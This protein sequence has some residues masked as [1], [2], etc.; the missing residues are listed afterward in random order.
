M[1]YTRLNEEEREIIS[2]GLAQNKSIRSI[3]KELGR[4]TSTI[5]REIKR[6][7]SKTGYWVFSANQK[8]KA[9]A[10]SRRKDKRR[11]MQNQRLRNYVEEKVKQGWSPKAIVERLIIDYPHDMSMRIS[12]EAIYQYIY[13]L[14]RG[15]LKQSLIEGLRQERKYRRAQKNGQIEETRGKISGMLAIEERPAEVEDRTVPGHWEGDLILGKY[16]RSALGTLVERT[17]R[18]TILVPL[19]DKKDAES[20][21]IAYAEA[22]KSVPEALKRSAPF[23][24]LFTW[25]FLTLTLIRRRIS[26]KCYEIQNL[27]SMVKPS[28]YIM[29][30]LALTCSQHISDTSYILALLPICAG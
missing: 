26:N 9:N 27:L 25:N 1:Q 20:V 10:S 5:S 11:L 21:R 23:G 4:S 24:A 30:Y 18:Y 7:Q 19:G 12:H 14:P 29:V 6:N 15:A 2:K 8:A 28:V 3:A 13:V 17:T 16:N 22:F